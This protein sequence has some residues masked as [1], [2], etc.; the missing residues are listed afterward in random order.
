M[1]ELLQL[2]STD[3]MV[4]LLPPKV[5]VSTMASFR[6]FERISISSI[7]RSILGVCRGSNSFR[8][9]APLD[10]Q[11]NHGVWFVGLIPT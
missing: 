4:P 11:G 10:P 3:T 7:H 1:D 9:R 8:L 2:R 5:V 6:G